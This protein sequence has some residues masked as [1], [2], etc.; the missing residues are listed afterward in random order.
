MRCNGYCLEVKGPKQCQ[1]HPVV[2]YPHCCLHKGPKQ[3]QDHPVVHYPH[4]CL[5][6]IYNIRLISSYASIES[7][8]LH[9]ESA[10]KKISIF[11][12]IF[13]EFLGPTKSSRN[14]KK[15]FEKKI[16][17]TLEV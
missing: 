3:C 14:A 9:F 4:C 11:F 6:Y 1:D 12:L 2:H 8:Q 5:H 15:K 16:S 13:F 7:L 17:C 10:T